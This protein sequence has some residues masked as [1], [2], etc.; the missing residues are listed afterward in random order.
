MNSPQL[1]VRYSLF[2]KNIEGNR[3]QV[4]G[5]R[6]STAVER[7]NKKSKSRLSQ[8]K[9]KVE[10]GSSLLPIALTKHFETQCVYAVGDGELRE[11][12]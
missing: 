2:R 8:P 6:P 3:R 9:C 10:A 5:F 1:L 4:Q 11:I 7:R 12:G